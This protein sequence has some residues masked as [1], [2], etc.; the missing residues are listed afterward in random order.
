M[1]LA[2]SSLCEI[3]TPNYWLIRILWSIQAGPSNFRPRNLTGSYYLWSWF[4]NI[5]IVVLCTVKY[6]TYP[7]ISGPTNGLLIMACG[8][9]VGVWFYGGFM[10]RRLWPYMSR[11]VHKGKHSLCSIKSLTL[12]RMCAARLLFSVPG[13]FSNHIY[14]TYVSTS[15]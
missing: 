12:S 10:C 5:R 7:D 8:M 3:S 4:L 6:S 1:Q 9:W 11:Q 15:I 14:R 2:V 13:F